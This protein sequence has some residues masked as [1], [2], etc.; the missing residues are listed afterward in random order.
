[1]T[2]PEA[3]PAPAPVIDAHHHFWDPARFDYPWMQGAEMA[4]LQRPFG[5]GDLAPLMAANGVDATIVVQ[6]CSSLE[7]TEALLAT[8]EETPSVAGVVGWIDLTDPDL[9]TVL[10][11]LASRPKL[12]GIRHQVHDEAD[13]RWLLRDDV[14]RGLAAVFDRGLAYDL[15]VR[16]R[17]LPAALEAARAFPHGRFVL[18][19]AAKPS[20]ASGITEDWRVGIRQL[21]AEP[22]VW[23]KVSGL[24]TE[25]DWHGWSADDLLPAVRHVWNIFG[26]H[27]LI[28]GSDWPVCLLAADYRQVKTAAET[29]LRTVGLQALGATA[30]A[31]IWGSNAIEAYRLTIGGKT[32]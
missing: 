24:V 32:C 11:N 28:F 15:L 1:M 23:C 17:E 7:E 29:C 13:S 2:A 30:D 31:R 3:V 8:A 6:C 19:H 20:I 16:T 9:A 26:E 18:D 14:Q 22:N 12:V 4:P 10:D 21:S 27:R 25:A 5:P